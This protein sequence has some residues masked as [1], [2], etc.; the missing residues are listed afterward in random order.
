MQLRVL[1]LQD[2]HAPYRDGRRELEFHGRVIDWDGKRCLFAIAHELSV[3]HMSNVW[4]DGGLLDALTR[5]PKKE[6]CCD[7]LEQ[8][9]ARAA[10]TNILPS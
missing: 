2:R 1:E 6:L 9:L 5:V 7:R 10:L 8:T 3:I 4:S